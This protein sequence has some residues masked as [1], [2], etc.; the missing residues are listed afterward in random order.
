MQMNACDK[1]ASTVF[2]HS[3]LWCELPICGVNLRSCV[4]MCACVFYRM[5]SLS[6][7]VLVSKITEVSYGQH[8]TKENSTT[9]S[10]NGTKRKLLA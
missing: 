1:R 4:R 7:P 6:N 2:N 9:R 10:V 3:I 8:D 5:Q